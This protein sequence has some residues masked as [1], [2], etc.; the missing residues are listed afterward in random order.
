[1]IER[2]FEKLIN[3]LGANGLLIIGLYFALY[4]PL[5]SMSKHVKKINEE[6]GELLRLLGRV[7]IKEVELDNED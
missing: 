2:F 4:R 7:K 3:E 6:L 5:N 1:M